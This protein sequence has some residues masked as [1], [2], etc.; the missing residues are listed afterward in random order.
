MDGFLHLLLLDHRRHTCRRPPAAFVGFKAAGEQLVLHLLATCTPVYG[1]D[2]SIVLR[3]MCRLLAARHK[4]ACRFWHSRASGSRCQQVPSYIVALLH[5]R[6]GGCIV[7][8]SP[9]LLGIA[10]LTYVHYGHGHAEWRSSGS[11]PRRQVTRMMPIGVPR[12]PYRSQKEGSWQW[13]D[14]WNCLVRFLLQ[15]ALW[16]LFAAHT[17]CQP[18]QKVCS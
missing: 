2:A 11:G 18:G 1:A 3:T 4:A 16:P 15:A 14:I 12:V 5:S 7:Q 9:R 17:Y 8:L 13:V 10:R 6:P